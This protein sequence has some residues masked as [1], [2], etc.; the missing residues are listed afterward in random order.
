MVNLGGDLR[1]AWRVFRSNPGF[2]AV[3]VLSLALGIGANTAIFTLLDAVVLKMLP[4]ENPDQLVV[5]GQG[6]GR[7]F[8]GESDPVNRSNTLYSHPLYRDLRDGNEIFQGIAALGSVDFTVYV[9]DPDAPS[10]TLPEAADARL[11]S[12]NYFEVLGVRPA[13][14]RA[15]HR[16]DDRTAGE[17]QVVVLSHGYWQRRF[18]ADPGIVGRNLLVN[19]QAYSVI[20]VAPKGFRG[21]TLGWNPDMWTPLAMQAEISRMGPMLEDREMGFLLLFGRLKAGVGVQ[22]ATAAMTLRFQQ[23]LRAEAGGELSAE[24]E[25]RLAQRRVEITPAHEAL[26]S[27]RRQYRE[28]LL[29]L[30][31]VV[32][33]VLL[34]ACANVANLLLA[35]ASSRRKEIGVRLALGAGRGRLIRQLLTESV[36]LAAAGGVLGLLIAP[37][38]TQFLVGM[39]YRS[40]ETIPFD[41]DPD[42]RILAFTCGISLLTGLLFGLAPALR[43]TRLDLAPTLKVNARGAIGERSRLGLSKSLVVIQ[44]AV[45]LLLLVGAGLFVGSLQNLRSLDLGFRPDHVLVFQLD[46]RGAGYQQEQLTAL[47]RRV[48]DAVR[49]IPGVESAGLSFRTL[50]GGARRSESVEVEGYDFQREEENAVRVMHVSP[51]YFDA[52]GMTLLEGR[53]IDD[54]DHE[55][56]APAVVVN[57]KF[58][59]HFF[60]ERPA[61]G[62]HIRFGPAGEAPNL[63]IV[64]IAGDAKYNEMREQAPEVAFVPVF[65]R[66]EF[67]ESLDIRTSGDATALTAE[68]RRVLGEVDRNLPIRNVTTL[69]AQV[70][71]RLSQERLLTTLTSFFGALAL[72]L[73]SI[74]LFG[75]MS[76]AVSGRTSEIGIR[77]ALGAESASVLWM[78][79]RESLGLVVIGAAAGLVAAAASTRL[80]SGLLYEMSPTDPA[81]FVASGVVLLAVAAFA[82][83]IPARRAARVDPIVA[84]RYE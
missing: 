42:G 2:T 62:G 67:I 47:Y 1:Y 44:V 35:R 34:I 15:I 20:G 36:L 17:S 12:G 59:E 24:R 14:G 73:A 4:V 46:P 70:E 6:L 83:Y 79:L 55:G 33:L 56:S 5:F 48:L 69:S 52:V 28:P 9:R 49:A 19:G 61:L 30:M 32:G 43:A 80:L 8:Y 27:L 76:Y 39:V 51:G 60:K 41:I 3:A 13:L 66:P 23:A 77:M 84:L 82:A 21:E 71:R 50:L 68:V 40:A 64:G 37:W 31:S 63:E 16:D 25:R 29:L 11:V 65:Q 54:R 7:G 75:V 38:A 22:Q 26:S 45:S 10:G 53:A 72:L 18:A 81:A 58:A 57:Q 78:V 74:G